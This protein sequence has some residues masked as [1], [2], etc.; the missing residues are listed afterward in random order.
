MSP[1]PEEKPDKKPLDFGKLRKGSKLKLKDGR[2]MHLTGLFL[3]SDGPVFMVKLSPTQ[4]VAE[5]V[6][7]DSID[8]LI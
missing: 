5:N 2:P 4:T 3:S 8:D 7:V 1:A 6:P